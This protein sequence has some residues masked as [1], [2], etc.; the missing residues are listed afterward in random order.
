M[1]KSEILFLHETISE[2]I[3]GAMTSEIAKRQGQKMDLQP[4]G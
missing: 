1:R 4:K 3:A 2:A